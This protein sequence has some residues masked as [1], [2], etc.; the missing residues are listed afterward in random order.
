M[1]KFF[2]F[3]ADSISLDPGVE[4]FLRSKNAIFMDF[5]SAAYVNSAMMPSVFSELIASAEMDRIT[6]VD[7]VAQQSGEAVLKEALQNA[8]QEMARLSEKIALQEAEI[9]SQE[10]QL[11]G[12]MKNIANLEAENLPFTAQ[13]NMSSITQSSPD[14]SEL[15][16]LSYDRLQ[17]EFQILRSQNI[18]AIA[19][20][21]VLE[22]ENYELRLEIEDKRAQTA[23]I[24]TH[25]A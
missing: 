23:P 14:A 2:T 4:S 18:E 7:R 13:G 24:K 22:E 1:T 16:S 5:G 15:A 9:T 25:Q 21:K 19:S 11:A 20:L 8:V 17:K 3:S 6:V 10:S 12:A